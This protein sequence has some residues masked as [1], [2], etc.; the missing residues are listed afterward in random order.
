MKKKIIPLLLVAFML[1]GC[2]NNPAV[3]ITNTPIIQKEQYETTKLYQELFLGLSDKVGKYTFADCKKAVLDLG[4]SAKITD[5]LQAGYGRIDIIDVNDF[6]LEIS[7]TPDRHNINKL[8]IISYSSPDNSYSVSVSDIL[9]EGKVNYNTYDIDRER[10]SQYVNTKEEM[11]K[12]IFSIAP[13][14]MNNY[15]NS[16]KDAKDIDVYMNV[17]G[18]Y[19]E[20]K[21]SFDIETNL[22]EKTEIILT[23][24]DG[25]NISQETVQVISGRIKNQPFLVNIIP[26]EKYSLSISMKVP[27]SQNTEVRSIIGNDGDHLIGDLIVQSAKNGNYLEAT[28]LVKIDSAGNLYI[29]TPVRN[30]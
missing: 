8:A 13:V 1:S 21:L 24:Y 14:K 12:F 4:Y 28:C 23:F 11:T 10:R 25:S 26:N 29:G 27:R 6:V 2:S 16:M 7:T 5:P 19:S 20:R 22:P 15:S 3:Q 18:F 17:T 9:L 30:E